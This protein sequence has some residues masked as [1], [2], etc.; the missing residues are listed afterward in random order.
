VHEVAYPET[1]EDRVEKLAQDD[2]HRLNLATG[3][4]WDCALTRMA[5]TPSDFLATVEPGE[6]G[7]TYRLILRSRN[8][9]TK[10]F[11][12]TMLM[13]TSWAYMHDVRYARSEILCNAATH[14]P[15][16]EMDYDRNGALVATF[17][18]S[19]YIEGPESAPGR[20]T[21]Q[22]PYKKGDVEQPLEMEADFAF[23]RTGVWLLKTVHSE[24]RGDGSG[25]TGEITVLPEDPAN[26]DAV[27][28]IRARLA[29]TRALIAKS[30]TL[31]TDPITLPLA[32]NANPD[33]WTRA[34]AA[35]LD[36]DPGILLHAV[37]TETLAE[38]LR[39]TLELVST[40]N[41]MAYDVA[42]EARL[43]DERGQTLGEQNVTV[44]V[45]AEQTP[46]VAEAVIVFAPVDGA[47][48]VEVSAKVT[49]LTAE[50]YG[51]RWMCFT[52]PAVS[53]QSR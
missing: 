37:S 3:L 2:R 1:D 31:S 28:A 35:A 18:F 52:S 4:G 30:A 46:G 49:A 7:S 10:I 26:A 32:M 20:I 34:D 38:G 15:S 19:D 42:V 13:F 53:P 51:S 6:D 40:A 5:R 8:R 11:A 22:I 25:S 45:R 16:S 41:W 29:A 21:A 50:F 23:A 36:A 44:N 14:R 9:E 24:F 43:L 39:V 48:T 27:N 12:G 33:L 47:R 17:H